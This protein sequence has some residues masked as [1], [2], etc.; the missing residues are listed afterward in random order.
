MYVQLIKGDPSCNSPASSN[1]QVL[2][3][4]WPESPVLSFEPVTMDFCLRGCQARFQIS[5]ARTAFFFGNKTSEHQNS[6]LDKAGEP[7]RLP[8]LEAAGIRAGAPRLY[9]LRGRGGPSPPPLLAPFHPHRL[10]GEAIWQ[11]CVNHP[12]TSLEE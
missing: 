3:C 9:L 10:E 6:L 12:E 7:Q 11:N 1:K 4:V 2:P 8:A 5:R